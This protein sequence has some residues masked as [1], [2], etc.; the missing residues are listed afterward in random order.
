MEKKCLS[1][2]LP[3]ERYKNNKEK[4][5]KTVSV[6][7]TKL[8]GSRHES[9]FFFFFLLFA[10]SRGA[11]HTVDSTPEHTNATLT[12]VKRLSEPGYQFGSKWAVLGR[13]EKNRREK[14]VRRNCA[15]VDEKSFAR[16]RRISLRA[17]GASRWRWMENGM[18][19]EDLVSVGMNIHAIMKSGLSSWNESLLCG[20]SFEGRMGNEIT[21]AGYWWAS[22]PCFALLFMLPTYG[23]SEKLLKSNDLYFSRKYLRFWIIYSS[24]GKSSVIKFHYSTLSIETF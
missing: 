5:F 13:I 7:R 1:L 23:R 15:R 19:Y 16:K 3:L 12:S 11:V 6:L 4:N 14:I 9:F 18:I 22:G 2:E 8:S 10:Q 20:K 21:T 17:R 24:K